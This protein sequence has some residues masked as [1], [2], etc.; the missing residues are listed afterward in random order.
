M[1]GGMPQ[2]LFGAFWRDKF[3]ATLDFSIQYRAPKMSMTIFL[4]QPAIGGTCGPHPTLLAT[5]MPAFHLI[6]CFGMQN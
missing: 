5:S 3:L 4:C 1:S 2:R 6:Y